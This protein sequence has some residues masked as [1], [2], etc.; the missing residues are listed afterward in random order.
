MPSLSLIL[1]TFNEALNIELFLDEVERALA[2]FDY[3]LIVVD[4]DSPDETW[5][6]VEARVSADPER[7]LRVIRRM[8]RRN[9]I[10]AIQ[11]GIDA[12]RGDLV[13]WMDCD[14]SAPPSLLPILVE[15]LERAD[16]AL[17]SR[18][19]EGGRDERSVFRR[20]PSRI[21][22]SLASLLLIPDFRDYTSGFVVA[23][24]AVV[25]RVRLRGVHG[26]YFIDLVVRA[27]R[28]G[29]KL[30]EIPYAL[31]D[32]QRGESKTEPGFSRKAVRYLVTIGRLW[33]EG[34]RRMAKS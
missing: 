14:L 33:W 25:E 8:R 23:K 5:R 27:H 10:T 21:V 30:V 29:F 32:R 28:Q 22:T 19:V 11:E 17:G 20:V 6:I 9:C 26:E 12:A 15:A 4:D 16:V 2:G 13:G 34:R 3:E 24:R 1:P 7:R 18:Y 31:V